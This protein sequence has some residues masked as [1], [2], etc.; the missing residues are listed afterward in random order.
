MSLIGNVCTPKVIGI[1]G[2]HDIYKKAAE[3]KK[4]L[5]KYIGYSG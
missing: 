1:L 2:I 3:K 5:Y 4:K